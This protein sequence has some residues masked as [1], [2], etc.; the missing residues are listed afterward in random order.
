MNTRA[1]LQDLVDNAIVQLLLHEGRKPTI[2][3]VQDWFERHD[4]G[5]RN[6]NA[7]AALVK[8]CWERLP[9]RLAAHTQTLELEPDVLELVAQLRGKLALQAAAVFDAD[10]ARF[11]AQLDE[12]SAQA[13]AQVRDAQLA[14]DTATRR[15]G[16]LTER[17]AKTEAGLAEARETAARRER[18]LGT[19]RASLTARIVAL[20]DLLAQETSTSAQLRLQLE[21][22]RVRAGEELTAYRDSASRL[23]A[24]RLLEIDRG[25]TELQAVRRTLKAERDTAEKARE[26]HLARL[27][28]AA[29]AQ[30]ALG[31]ELAGLRAQ[32]TDRTAQ[33][34][35]ATLR[36]ESL[37][38]TLAAGRALAE[39][40]AQHAAEL[41]R[42]C[43]ALESAQRALHTRVRR[44]EALA[45]R[46]IRRLRGL[47]NEGD[48][49]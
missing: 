13:A 29:Q 31:D 42:R 45:R 24:E 16:E 6:T 48:R 14:A 36:A 37:E 30:R 5:R 32:L 15:A 43:E 40:R 38:Q 39:T 27:E 34:Q 33:C 3:S 21:A 46:L 12:A 22:E 49:T 20:Q 7:V 2:E 1:A 23:D 28:Q 9:A 11:A 25:R 35:A 10:R 8:G 41:A 44:R 47:R 17:L 26:Q 19:E 4:F 18:E